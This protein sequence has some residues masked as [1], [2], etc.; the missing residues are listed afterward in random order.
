MPRDSLTPEQQKALAPYVAP[1]I[2]KAGGQVA[3]ARI[4]G[5]KAHTQ[6]SRAKKTGGLSGITA[7]RLMHFLGEDPARIGLPSLG[8]RL[9]SLPS[10]PEAAKAASAM[11]NPK[12]VDEVGGF[13]P[14]APVSVVTALAL[15]DLAR[16]WA[17]IRAA[18]ADVAPESGPLPPEDDDL[19]LVAPP[20]EAAAKRRA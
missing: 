5:L 8:R 19:P 15:V 12:D 18:S 9:R 13:V 3:L 17:A 1:A 7:L 11:A 10:W 4:V 14:P 20:P 6:L 2:E 16:G